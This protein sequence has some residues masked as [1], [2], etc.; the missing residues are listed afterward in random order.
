MK[1]YYILAAIFFLTLSS[2][3]QI[4]NIPDA[5]FKAQ[6]LSGIATQSNS[7]PF[8]LDANSNGEIE[9]EEAAMVDGIGLSQ[10]EIVSLEGI[11][12]FT[13]L[14]S[15]VCMSNNVES[16]DY[17][18]PL[19][20][21]LMFDGNKLTQ[22]NMAHFPR[23]HFLNCSGN[24]LT[25]LDLRQNE[26]SLVFVPG[27]LL[28][29]VH[30]GALT[31]NGAYIDVSYNN[32]T[33]LEIL[34]PGKPLHRVE[35]NNNPLVNFNIEAVSFDH[36]ICSNTLLTHL[37]LSK[38]GRY[39]EFILGD[40]MIT[41]NPNLR[42][43]NLKNNQSHFCIRPAS[44]DCTETTF[45]LQNN[46]LLETVCADEGSETEFLQPFATALGFSLT[47]DCVLDVND[48]V[49]SENT[50]YPNPAN[51][52][53]NIHSD[54]AFNQIR[55]LNMLGQVV[56]LANSAPKND[57]TINVMDLKTGT[58]FVEITSDKGKSVQKLIKQ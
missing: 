40:F 57:A 43:I 15:L 44:F 52:I 47:T 13:N 50:I 23:L 46:P 22:L 10:G 27:N 18:L 42:S 28:T 37:D 19:L 58:Y 21:V 1:Q 30:F 41:D 17:D 33:S 55:I 32:L 2:S 20:E 26:M 11:Q 34:A 36:L 6:L 3:A 8:I 38:I 39:Q 35:F 24:L 49:V 51:E 25:S 31:E 4:I 54:V 29:E 48:T 53:L 14:K 9:V 5:I 45:T 7:Q 16:L 56:A 12:Y